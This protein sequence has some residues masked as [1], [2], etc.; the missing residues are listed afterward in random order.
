VQN[1]ATAETSLPAY[2]K[3]KIGYADREK[4]FASR[5]GWNVHQPDIPDLCVDVLRSLVEI[6]D[7][8]VWQ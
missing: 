7:R 5:G 1:N 3:R 2:P 8:W 6:L 4:G